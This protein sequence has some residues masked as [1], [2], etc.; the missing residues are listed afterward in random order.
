MNETIAYMVTWT[1]YGTWMQR[2][3]KDF[4]KDGKVMAEDAGLR[5]AKN[6]WLS[7]KPVRLSEEEKR[8]ARRAI[9]EKA[10]RIGQRIL[11][12]AVCS[13]HVHIVFGYD[14][15]GIEETVRRYKNAATAALRANGMSGKVWTKGYDKRYCFDEEALKNRINYV[16]RHNPYNGTREK[17]ADWLNLLT[18]EGG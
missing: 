16:Q 10:K 12:I 5:R 6:K 2:E 4:D 14:G 1:T 13:K 15:R 17:N 18:G 3:Q 8:V 7:Q 9:V 11:A